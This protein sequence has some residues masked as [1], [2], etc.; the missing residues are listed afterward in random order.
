LEDELAAELSTESTVQG[1]GVHAAQPYL[2]VGQGEALLIR[3]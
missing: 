2:E 3:S 1:G